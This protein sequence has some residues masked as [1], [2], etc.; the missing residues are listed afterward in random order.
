VK[1]ETTLSKHITI[2]Q[3]AEIGTDISSY[4]GSLSYGNELQL[5][6]SAT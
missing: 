3:T 6:Q 1:H 2:T 5:Y 4:W